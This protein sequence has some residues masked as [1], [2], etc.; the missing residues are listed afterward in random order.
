MSTNREIVD[1]AWAE[2]LTSTI[3]GAEW[4]NRVSNGYKGKPYNWQATAYGRAKLLLD[5]VVDTTVV[6]PPSLAAEKHLAIKQFTNYNDATWGYDR[7]DRLVAGEWASQQAAS[8][9]AKPVLAYT[10]ACLIRPDYWVNMD[11]AAA[12]AAGYLLTAGGVEITR[13]NESS[14]KVG[15][16]GS[17]AY[18]NAWASE[19]IGRAQLKGWQ[20]VFIDNVE[21]DS[22]GS[23]L[24]NA[25][26]DAYTTQIAWE[27]AMVGFV[28]AV[29]TQL[30]AAGL[31]VMVNAA[32]FVSGSPGWDNATDTKA[33]ALRLKNHI[34][35]FMVEY[36]LQ[37]PDGTYITRPSGTAAWYE[38]WDEWLSVI[39][40]VEAL[41]VDFVGLT[42][43]PPGD[44]VDAKYAKASLLLEATRAGT[45]LMLDADKGG[46][47]NPYGTLVAKDLGAPLGAKYQS[48][49]EWRR[50]F[51]SGTV[52]VNPTTKVGIIP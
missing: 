40:H 1:G 19:V 13:S 41:G 7:Y 28:D 35:G 15:N 29:G 14:V 31:Y 6:T 51:Q 25:R 34:D 33:Y 52:R 22:T 37:R 48:A 17:A 4:Q 49:S 21:R 45:C 8:E 20:G 46:G 30:Q 32:G 2:I 42:E 50:D 3:S 43:V 5:Q 26:P 47:Q 10:N 24:T 11:L 39:P 36:W 38:H 44:S 27:N 9:L 12:R 23:G 16:V 18:R